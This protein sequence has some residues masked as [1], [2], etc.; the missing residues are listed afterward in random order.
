MAG[1]EQVHFILVQDQDQVRTLLE[2]TIVVGFD[3]AND[4][5]VLDITLPPERVRDVQ[6]HFDAKR[7]SEP[8][9][10]DRGLPTL[11]G[12]HPKHSLKNLAQCLLRR[13]IQKGPHT[14]VEDAMATMDLY[15]WDRGRIE[16][17]D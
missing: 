4:L 14:A 6:R 17:N 13:S 2:D 16:E 3:I 15:L 12:Q 9:L 11:G 8:D 10:S 7:C 1:A 5:K